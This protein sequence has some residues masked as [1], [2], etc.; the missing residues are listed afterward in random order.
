MKKTVSFIAAVLMTG[1]FGFAQLTGIKTIP[2]TYPSLS[3][4]IADLNSQGVGAGGVTF[5]LAAGYTETLSSST[6]GLITTTTATASKPIVFQRSGTGVNPV[7]TAALLSGTSL[8]DGIIILQGTDY[9]TFDGIDVR[10]NGAN[11]ANTMEWGYAILVASPTDASQH[12]HIM[13]CSISMNKTNTYS[14]GVYS[15]T[16]PANS[17]D[18]IIPTDPAGVVSYCDI[19]NCSISNAY[20]GIALYGHN[21]AAPNTLYGQNN[22]IGYNQGNTITNFGGTEWQAFAVYTICQNNIVVAHNNI[23]G[24]DGTTLSLYGIYLNTSNNAN[25]DIYGNRVELHS[26]APGPY[27]LYG[28]CNTGGTVGTTNVVNIYD[29]IVENCTQPIAGNGIWFL[30]NNTASSFTTNVHGNTVRNN[31]RVATSTTIYLIYLSTATTAGTENIYENQLYGNSV[32]GTG[33]S[34]VYGL[35]CNNTSVKKNVYLNNIYG[36]ESSHTSM[37]GIFTSNGTITNIYKNRI[38]DQANTN[39]SGLNHGIKIN[40]GTT[41]YCYNNVI[42]DLKAPVS[43]STFALRGIDIEGSTSTIG[44]YYNTVFLNG[45]GSGANLGSAALYATTNQT[46]D[47]RNNILVNVS[48]SNGTGK[49]VA[50]WRANTTL[51]TYSSI[52]GNNDFY[53]G[54]PGVKNL[55]FYDGTNSMQTLADY[56]AFVSPA[57]V[58]SFTELPSFTNAISVPYDLHINPALPTQCESGGVTI[59]TPISIATDYDGVPRFPNAGYPNNPSFPALAPDAGA[60][61]FAGINVDLNPPIINYSPLTNTS[62]LT[63]RTLT[64]TINDVSGI[65]TSGAGLPVCYWKINSGVYNAAQGVHVPGTDNYTFTYG[66]GVSTGDVVSYY[67]AAQDLATPP[68]TGVRPSVGTGGL[69]SNPPACSIPPSSPSTYTILPPISGTVT[70]G[71]GG[72]YPSLTGVGGLFQALNSKALSGNLTV[73][74]IS[75][76]T[77]SGTYALNKMAEDPPGNFT[78][79]IQSSAATERLISG[80]AG[81]AMIRFSGAQHVTID[82]RYNGAGKYL[83]FRNTNTAFADFEFSNDAVYNILRDCYWESGNTGTSNAATGAIRFYG[84][85]GSAGNSHNQVINNVIRDFSN[86]SSQPYSMIFSTGSASATNSDNLIAGNEILN[87]TTYGVYFSANNGDNWVITGNSLYNTLTVP[88]TTSIKAL[89]VTSGSASN[90][91]TIAG[92]YIGGSAPMCGGTPWVLNTSGTF[93]GIYV[94]AGTT[95]P[96]EVYNNII[97]NFHNSNTGAGTFYGIYLSSVGIFHCGTMGGNVIG[98]ATS[99]NSIQLDG[100]MAFR[101]IYELGTLDGNAIENNIIGN[102]TWS[103]TSGAQTGIYGLFYNAARVQK[104]KVF[105]IGTTQAGFTPTIYGLYSDGVAGITNVIANNMIDLDGGAATNPTLYGFY[106]NATNT[107]VSKLYFNTIY[108]HGPA[109]TTSSTFTWRRTVD[110]SIV[111]NDNIFFNDRNAGGTGSHYA[112]YDQSTGAQLASDYNDIRTATG[113][114]GFYN[115][116]ILTNLADWQSATMN[117]AHSVSLNPAFVSTTDLH[118]S[119]HDLD[120]IG[121]QVSGIT[122]DFSGITRGNPPDMGALEFPAIPGNITVTGIVGSTLDTCYNALSTITVAGGGSSFTIQPGGTVT[123][124]AGEKILYLPG[125]TVAPGGYM[126]GYITTDGQYCNSQPPA[127]P[128][129]VTGTGEQSLYTNGLLF[130]VYPNPTS[131]NFTIV[132]KGENQPDNL[133]VELYNMQG[134]KV[135]SEGMTGVRK[136]EFN[137]S[138]KP[139]GLYF[140]RIVSSN[141]TETIKLVKTR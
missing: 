28:I 101:G 78:I 35:F 8:S 53:A 18:A 32:T 113:M 59:L 96:S 74:V 92:N 131:G 24:G 82:G 15:N 50:Y 56:K 33:T 84:S 122:T 76:L 138:E 21:S 10:E 97:A 141:D 55:I 132:L 127:N 86:T 75:D 45:S 115:G 136:H 129:F 106:E 39:A 25:V 7:I 12:I 100:T 29:N 139:A 13:N 54:V 107:S 89:N 85:T 66:A 68:N 116:F 83:R 105:K 60:Y 44:L 20:T 27:S 47:L 3:S 62:M 26:D 63:N 19:D 90:G 43:T 102:I 125:T 30:I 91:H 48:S 37:F 46:L 22:R 117:D 69:T 34:L 112:L 58:N 135:L 110:A 52:S 71:A 64:A 73:N 57:D 130:T 2:G 31:T 137:I 6:A 124:I 17:T 134:K 111:M 128:V 109:T 4:A 118:P 104:N 98:S 103:A 95:T 51:G 61:E 23:N 88:L 87:F 93:Y 121:I 80:N 72:D 9:V 65:P 1:T 14:R 67:I 16:H 133:N 42:S 41:T 99:P 5:N 123:M 119:N 49:T 36:N 38:Y 11:A 108:I 94:S 79:T 140:I 40:G 77:E 70:V 81:V 120:N 114:L 126:H